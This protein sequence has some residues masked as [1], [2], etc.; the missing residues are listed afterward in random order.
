MP[1]LFKVVPE[2]FFSVLAAPGKI[3]Y[4]DCILRIF[5]ITSS[6]LSFGV[7]RD[8]LVDDLEYYFESTMSADIEE[9]NTGSMSPRDKANFMLRKL[10]SCGWITVDVDHSYVQRVNF[11][12]YAIGI[13]QTLQGITQG[14]KE[15]Y[16]GYIYTIYNLCRAKDLA[17]IGLLEIVKNTDALIT[18]LKSLN[19]N[20]KNYIDDLT[21]HSSVAEIL[22][23]LLNDYYSNVVDKA[24][25][26]LLTSDNVSKFRPAIVETLERCARSR[27][28]L[29]RAAPE[30]AQIREVPAEEAKEQV[31]T[32]LHEVVNAFQQMDEILDEI[33]RKNTKYQRAA[34]NRAKFLLTSSDDTRGQLRNILSSL[35]DAIQ[36][37]SLNFNGIYD[38]DQTD[39]LIKIFSVSWLDGSSLYAPI[40][41]KKEFK[42]SDIEIHEV[43]EAARIRKRRQ[44]EQKM[45]NV[46]TPNKIGKYVLACLGDRD[47]MM[48]GE[49]VTDEESFIKLIYVRLYGQRKRMPYRI[50]LHEKASEVRGFRFRNFK[51]IRRK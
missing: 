12:D 1:H 51:I 15:E 32:M 26:R 34:I 40:E 48:A 31:L 37:R 45:D 47:E 19:A 38:L 27:K 41:G 25:H 7:E 23:A 11:R 22:D 13:I 6:Q 24:Y 49:I 36:E 5:D 33:N 29:D 4:W 2:N 10:E 9:E 17:G 42:P 3:A 46:L 35:N 43:D 30:I 8:I 14:R 20:I 28:F 18:S 50:E 39:E 16:Q 44:M 21:K